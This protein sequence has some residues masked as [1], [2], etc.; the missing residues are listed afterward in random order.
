MSNKPAEWREKLKNK[1]YRYWIRDEIEQIIKEGKIDRSRFY[2]YSKNSYNEIIWKFYYGFIDY[3][4]HPK[5]SLEYCWLHFRENDLQMLGRLSTRN[6]EWADFLNSIRSIM[7][8][9]HMYYLILSQGW[10]YEGCAEEIFSVLKETDGLLEDFYIVSRKFGWT[11][12]YCDDGESA[13][14][15]QIKSAN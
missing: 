15:L 13:V 1:P 9:E 7:P 14:L 6:C 12:S 4:K 5:V 10:V 3:K 2:E 11:I 8:E